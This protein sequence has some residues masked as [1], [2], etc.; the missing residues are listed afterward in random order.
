MIGGALVAALFDLKFDLM[1]YLLILANDFFTAAY[2]VFI[3]RALNLS[4]SQM[5]CYRR[6]LCLQQYPSLSC[7]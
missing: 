3:K 5:R 2:G 7:I 1:G 4:I 6:D